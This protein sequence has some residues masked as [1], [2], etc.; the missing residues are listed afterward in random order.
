MRALRFTQQKHR[1]KKKNETLKTNTPGVIN[2]FYVCV[3]IWWIITLNRRKIEYTYQQLIKPSKIPL[4]VLSKLCANLQFE[5]KINR[6]W[7]DSHPQIY[8][9][10]RNRY[11]NIWS[12]A[13]NIYRNKNIIDSS[14]FHTS[15]GI[16]LS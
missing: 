12:I 13:Y 11:Y 4:V 1:I 14:T 5:K 9:Y 3:N 15:F 6:N 16:I 7:N 10:Y 2:S 8:P